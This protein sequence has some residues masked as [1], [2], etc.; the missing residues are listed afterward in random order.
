[1]SWY[2]ETLRKIHILYVSPPWVSE[3]GE[4]FDAQEYVQRLQDAGVSLVQVYA[5]DHHGVT[6]YPCSLG[7]PYPRDV[8]AELEAACHR[9]G[10]R[11]MAYYSV[12][13]DNYALGLHP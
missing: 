10:I 9:A 7:L 5:K 1:M 13:F 2:N 8:M 12:C 11:I 6:Y 4:R 3:R